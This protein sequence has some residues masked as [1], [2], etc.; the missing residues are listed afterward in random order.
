MKPRI[1]GEWDKL[2]T[3]NIATMNRF[4]WIDFNH[5]L[6][7]TDI[8][9]R[10]EVI[11]D[12]PQNNMLYSEDH[13]YYIYHEV[14]TNVFSIEEDALAEEI[15]DLTSQVLLLNAKMGAEDMS[16]KERSKL[17]KTRNLKLKELRK[18]FGTNE[19]ADSLSTKLSDSELKRVENTVI[20]HL[21]RQ[22]KDRDDYYYKFNEKTEE[23]EIRLDEEHEL[24]SL[25]VSAIYKLD[26]KIDNPSTAPSDR[27]RMYS[28]RS[29]FIAH[30]R[31]LGAT[32]L[33]D[34]LN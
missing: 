6:D 20:G 30:L 19:L 21:N 31:K 5:I 10:E 25:I 28:I 22:N 12:L 14:D 32:E 33:A 18:T 15:D 13:R 8:N 7:T 2:P 34:N 23:F 1:K 16:P 17:I 3:V 24:I 29:K 26:S 11:F 9:R 27:C 4:P